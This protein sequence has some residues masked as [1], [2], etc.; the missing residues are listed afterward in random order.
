MSDKESKSEKQTPA[1]KSK[2]IAQRDFVLHQNEHHF[3]ISKGD[4]LDELGVPEKFDENL[5]TEKVL[6]G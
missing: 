2:R 1:K 5:N 4:D 3:K 6:K